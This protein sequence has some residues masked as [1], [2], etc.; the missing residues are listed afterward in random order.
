MSQRIQRWTF[1]GS[2]NWE[3][4]LTSILTADSSSIYNVQNIVPLVDYVNAIRPIPAA[5]GM[6]KTTSI[7]CT[8]SYDEKEK[9]D[10]LKSAALTL[11]IF[12]IIECSNPRS[13]AVSCLSDIHTQ[14]A[15]FVGVDSNYG[16]LA[17]Q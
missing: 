8:H 2:S 5:I 4:S 12:P 11:G 3:S 7:W 15:D 6:C 10:V 16:Y 13:D 17:R 14:K 9:C 1:F